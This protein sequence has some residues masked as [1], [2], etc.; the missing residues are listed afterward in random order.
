MRILFIMGFRKNI[1]Y[2]YSYVT[3][4]IIITRDAFH[5]TT[6][7]LLPVTGDVILIKLSDRLVNNFHYYFRFYCSD[8]LLYF[9]IF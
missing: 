9:Y 6:C 7:S 4:T 8:I 1:C 5:H 2:M 3:M